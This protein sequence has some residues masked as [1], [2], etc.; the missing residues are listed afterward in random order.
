[1]NNVRCSKCNNF[2]DGVI[3]HHELCGHAEYDQMLNFCPYCGNQLKDVDMD[4]LIYK[5]TEK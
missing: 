5:T 3:I 1:M 2:V 4:E